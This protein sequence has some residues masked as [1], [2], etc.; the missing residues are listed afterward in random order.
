MSKT[1][2]RISISV[3]A[4]IAAVTLAFGILTTSRAFANDAAG[5]VMDAGAYVRLE[6][7]SSGIRFQ[8]EINDYDESKEYGMLIAPKL[9]IDSCE[10]EDYITELQALNPDKELAI[11]GVVKEENGKHIITGALANIRYDNLN[12][13]W[14]GI[15][16]EKTTTEEGV[17]Y[18]YATVNNAGD[19]ERSI[20]SVASGVLNAGT[21]TNA[22]SIAI[23]NTFINRAANKANGVAEENKDSKAD[24]TVTIPDCGD[25]I[26]AGK[27]AEAKA[28]IT[29]AIDAQVKYVSDNEDVAKIDKNG[30]VTAIG[31]GVA[32][33]TASV[34]GISDE[35]LLTVYEY[36]N[37]G[38]F[39]K[40]DYATAAGGGG[41]VSES[42]LVSG[43]E[44]PAGAPEGITSAMKY[45]FSKNPCFL[46]KSANL[47]NYSEVND[48]D[49]F[50]FTFYAKA[51]STVMYK[52]YLD[53]LTNNT[54]IGGNSFTKRY[55]EVMYGTNVWTTLRLYGRDF[56]NYMSGKTQIYERFHFGSTPT[57][58]YVAE[59][60]F[61]PATIVVNENEKANVALPSLGMNNFGY[62]Y[63]VNSNGIT[64][65]QNNTEISALPK[66]E[67]TVTYTDITGVLDESITRKIVV[68]SKNEFYLDDKNV[69]AT[70]Y[71]AGN[72]GYGAIDGIEKTKEIPAGKDG[73]ALKVKGKS[74]DV[75]ANY[76]AS[77]I[78]ISFNGIDLKSI[79]NES[80][81]E[82]KY[83]LITLYYEGAAGTAADSNWDQ[84]SLR[85]S[86]NGKNYVSDSAITTTPEGFQTPTRFSGGM[87][88]A[89]AWS[90]I[91]IPVSYLKLLDEKY[92]LTG[93]YLSICVNARGVKQVGANYYVQSVSVG[94]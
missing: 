26:K 38:L 39:E 64:G 52:G 42:V 92:D 78:W 8:A 87:I 48:E 61:V 9:L 59:Y 56:K 63:T 36:D 3:I 17:S 20:V 89:G 14:T 40:E 23:L 62:N 66:G 28:A 6:K 37:Y 85:D 12:L 72:V 29:P 16:F 73:E 2:K 93:K 91:K 15:A 35:K 57:A 77:N 25:L 21:E 7:D 94:D 34:A 84:F 67:Y 11:C 46:V 74:T 45:V 54:D 80:E 4:A 86:V 24:I 88:K 76:N 19:N 68:K 79:V 90:E 18:K 10:T 31:A 75:F 22:E 49:Y 33:I 53:L 83:L 71:N 50:E 65:D 47:V 30:K 69:N 41:T 58:I 60:K 13:V 27:S 55:W 82:N 44:V 70:Y 5:I 51:D 1:L 81:W 32:T 43:E